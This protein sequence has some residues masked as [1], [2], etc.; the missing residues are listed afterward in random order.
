MCN[1]DRSAETQLLTMGLSLIKTA[2]EASLQDQP[3]QSTDVLGAATT[4]Y[5]QGKITKSQFMAVINALDEQ[6]YRTQAYADP[7]QNYF[8]AKAYLDRYR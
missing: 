5:Q 6:V 3:S 1:I 7:N 2:M 4:A 8:E